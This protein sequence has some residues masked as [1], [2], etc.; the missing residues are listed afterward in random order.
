[1]AGEHKPLLAIWGATAT[2]KTTLGI[3]LAQNLNG[4]IISADSRQIY[5]QMD[6]GT[7][8]PTPEEQA[9]ATH[10]L[11]DIVDP[12]YSL[13]L[14]EYQ[15]LAYAHIHKLHE[16]SKLPLL[17]GG[18]GQYVSAVVEGWSIPRVPP[19]PQLRA[20]L[21]AEAEAHG[22]A[23]FHARLASVDPEAAAN[24]HPHNVRRVI[25]ALE[26]YLETGTPISV[27]QRK[28]PPP[29]RIL[30]LGL[31]M[32]REANFAR[33]DARVDAMLARGFLDEVQTLLAQGYSRDL[34]AMSG[35]GYQELTAHLLDGWPLEAA[36]QKTKVNTH[37]FIRRQDVWFRGHEHGTIW[38]D[39][40]QPDHDAIAA[41]VAQWLH[42]E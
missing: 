28:R 35:L 12:D 16:R 18:T 31:A 27:L 7:A 36:V 30:L 5:R 25:R 8:K 23:A 29:Y 40:T 38:Q 13:S 19:N 34:P 37:A 9:Q 32:P 21:E 22:Y 1:M 20:E 41:S 33:A 15:A 14:A 10:H 26:V 17:V 24:I 6:I 4:E 2:G 39:A 11:I 3:H 42:K